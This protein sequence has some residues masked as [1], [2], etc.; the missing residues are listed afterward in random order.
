MLVETTQRFLDYLKGI[1]DASEHTIRN[2]GIDLNAFKDYLE[3]ENLAFPDCDLLKIDRK[4]IRGF[5][6]WLK[7]NQQSKRTI[8]RRLSTLRS[9]FR[10]ALSQKIIPNDPTEELDHPKLERKLPVS[11]NYDQVVHLFEQP[12][13]S[14][15][16]GFRDRTIME[17][18]YS[19]GL[20]ISEL[21]ALNRKD[22]DFDHF[23]VKLKGKGKK[24]RVI[25]ITKNAG[26]WI[27]QYLVHADRF[28]GSKIHSPQ[29]DE[30]AV[31]LN[32][33]GTRITTRS[34]DRK[35]DEY[36]TQSGLS[37]K[38]TPHTI[39]HTIATHW[40]ENGMDLKTIQVLL[41]HSSLTTTTIYTQ[42]STKLKKKVYD[43]THPRA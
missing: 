34:I 40:L 1:K 15:Y 39:R 12:D 37:G 41:G 22:I 19:S 10:F 20:R 23:T 4:M 35:F 21:A 13:L 32:K 30:E 38:I 28:Y 27:K 42:V 8:A 5:L 14:S 36:L 2:Y 3:S 7:L 6:A 17:L 29:V 26:D 25:P 11:L 16:L 18:L 33:H 24:E 31:F 9:F 43:E